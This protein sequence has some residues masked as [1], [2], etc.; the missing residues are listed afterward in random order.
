[1]HQF[2]GRTDLFLEHAPG[3]ATFNLMQLARPGLL[4]DLRT[5]IGRA[6]K[7]NKATRKER[8]LVKLNGKTYEINV[9]VVPFKVPQSAKPWFLIIF[10]ETT[11][12]SKI[13][14]SPTADPE[15][16]FPQRELTEMRRELAASKR[17]AASHHRGTGS[18][19]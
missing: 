7:T 17:I 14:E 18:N 10:D 1:M 8:S 11:K 6:I 13:A 12:R 4:A 15:N 2:R 9:Q 3:P 19:Q 5:T 16:G